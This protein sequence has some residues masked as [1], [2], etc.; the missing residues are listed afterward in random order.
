M[1][2]LS[3]KHPRYG[4]RRIT[5]LLREESWLV[6]FKRVYRL[7]SQE[8]LKVPKKQHQ[9]LYDGTSA[10]SCHKK[11]AEHCNH[12]WSYDFLSERLENGRRIRLL[13]VIDEYT[14]ECLALDVARSFRGEDVVELLRYLCEGRSDT[15]APGGPTL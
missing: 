5:I 10:N 11:R 3:L 9:R 8:G 6:N 14:R 1:L 13:V 2:R 7:W 12:V 15:V 4:Y